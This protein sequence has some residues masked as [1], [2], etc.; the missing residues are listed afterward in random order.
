M[1]QQT[2]I[3]RHAWQPASNSEDA[4]FLQV[5]GDY[6]SFSTL[7]QPLKNSPYW[8]VLEA[9]GPRFSGYCGAGE[10]ER[11]QFKELLGYDVIA[12]H[13]GPFQARTIAIPMIKTQRQAGA[14]LPQLPVEL[15]HTFIAHHI[16]HDDHEGEEARLRQADTDRLFVNRTSADEDREFKLW[17]NIHGELFGKHAELEIKKV[18]KVKATDFWSISERLGYYATSLQAAYVANHQE[19]IPDN[20][21]QQLKTMSVEVGGRHHPVL[22]QARS[23]IALVDVM[24]SQTMNIRRKIEQS[25]E[26]V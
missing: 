6:H 5:W 12:E 3:L 2:E 11:A 1:V 17:K 25:G 4:A 8:D 9:M 14:E 16:Q 22:E 24:L 10:D 18:E 26:S 19:G 21:R 23:R 7:R 20:L 13:H 15:E